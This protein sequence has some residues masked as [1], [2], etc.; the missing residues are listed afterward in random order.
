M[1]E[2]LEMVLGTN[3][4]Y[5]FFVLYLHHDILNRPFYSCVLSCQAFDLE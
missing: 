1:L 3:V 5:K 4:S 2:S